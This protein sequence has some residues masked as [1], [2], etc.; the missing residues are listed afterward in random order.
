MEFN[1]LLSMAEFLAEPH[2]MKPMPKYNAATEVKIPHPWW[3]LDRDSVHTNLKDISECIASLTKGGVGLDKELLHLLK[4]A[5]RL[6]QV[7]R[8]DTVKVA[9]IGAQG[10]GKSLLINALLD[11]PGLSLTGAKGFACTS[12]IIKYAYG[13]GDRFAAEVKFLNARKREDMIDEHIRSY[14]DY[15]ND[16]EDSDDEG[17]P[18]TRSLQQDEIDRKR[19]TTA[20]DFFDTIFGSRDEF[21]CNWA[22]SPVNTGEFK[23]ICQL[24][25]TEAM[26]EHDTNSQD[27]VHFSKNTPKELLEVI[28]PFLSR[29]NDKI[30]LWPIVDCVTIRLNHA[31]LQQGIEI[32]DLPG[33]V[34]GSVAW[35]HMLTMFRVWRHQYATSPPCRRSQG[36]RGC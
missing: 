12:A 3:D 23:S 9:L 17:G 6:E 20:E 35:R 31:L 15:H 18:L 8:E 33:T 36:H 34:F 14:V 19:K 24:K 25:C 4:T 2:R 22:S 27:I 1:P 13:P 7:E 29:V 32:I 21:M 28:K 16:F 26:N 30:C 10:A 11:S 5:T